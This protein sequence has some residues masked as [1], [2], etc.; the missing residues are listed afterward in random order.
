MR[1]SCLIGARC[2]DCRKLRK[3]YAEL[4]KRFE[5]YEMYNLMEK[6]IIEA[7]LSDADQKLAS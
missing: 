1:L 5:S 4:R 3:H 2:S 6:C 7:K